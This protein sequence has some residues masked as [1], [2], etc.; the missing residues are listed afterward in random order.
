MRVVFESDDLRRLYSDADV[1]L[2]RLGPDVTRAFRKKVT[3][4]KS[5]GSEQELR[6][7]RSLHL[8]KLRGDRAGQHSIRLNDQWRLILRLEPG[9]CGRFVIVVDVVDYH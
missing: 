3:L 4:L 1:H 5:V 6:Q 7:F 8:E 9:A 2:K